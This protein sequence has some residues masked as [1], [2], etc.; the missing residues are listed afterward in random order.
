MKTTLSAEGQIGIPEEIRRSDRLAVGD[1][2]KLSRLTAGQYLLVK[3]A[4]SGL[5]IE[6]SIGSDGLPLIRAAGMITSEMVRSI[7]AQLT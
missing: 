4:P 2:F 1:S 6:V 7:E 5:P 3:E